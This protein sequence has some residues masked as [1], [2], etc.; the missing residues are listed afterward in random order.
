MDGPTCSHTPNGA[1][2]FNSEFRMTV[3]DN[4]GKPIPYIDYNED[5][6]AGTLEPGASKE[7]EA[8]M[9][10][11]VK[12]HSVTMG[13]ASAD[14]HYTASVSGGPLPATMMPKL[15]NPQNPLGKSLAFTFHHRWYVGSPTPGKGVQV[16]EHLG[17]FYSDHGAYGA[18]KSPPGTGKGNSCPAG[19]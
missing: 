9:K 17:K 7:W 10:A 1:L 12:G 15:S 19:S 8:P 5:F 13:D 2:G 14:D 3:K 4:F 16:S 11:R 18:F 6:D